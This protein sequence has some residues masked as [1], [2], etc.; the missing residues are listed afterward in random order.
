MVK[1]LFE[2]S[3]KTYTH[4]I[5]KTTPGWMALVNTLLGLWEVVLPQKKFD[6]VARILKRKFGAG[7]RRDE[8][9]FR[10][11]KDKLLDYFAGE[12]TAFSELLD[13]GDASD[14]DRGVWHVTSTIPW[15]EVRSY[16]WVAKTLGRPEAAVAV[17][18]ALSRN[19]LPIIVPCHRV[20]NKG[21]SLGGY[22]AGINFK[23]MLLKIEGR[24]W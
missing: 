19:R 9:S 3:V 10:K 6:D 21:G 12:A 14:F 17:G 4:S 22:S 11:L 2:E 16:Q 15:G 18:Q 5:F 8:M 13:F 1:G 7:L 23:R 20:I 24:L